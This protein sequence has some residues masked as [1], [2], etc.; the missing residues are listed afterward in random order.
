VIWEVVAQEQLYGGC[1]LMALFNR[2]FFVS[3]FGEEG[4]QG[5]WCSCRVAEF[6]AEV[7]IEPDPFVVSR[8]AGLCHPDSVEPALECSLQFWRQVHR[9]RV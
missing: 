1:G 2:V 5:G 8:A 7:E 4:A 3:K 6:L 9:Q